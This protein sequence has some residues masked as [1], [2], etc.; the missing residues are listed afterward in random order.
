MLNDGLE[1]NS[2]E[3]DEKSQNKKAQPDAV[4]WTEEEKARRDASLFKRDTAVEAPIDAV[5]HY[6]SSQSANRAS[7]KIN[8]AF[9]EAYKLKKLEYDAYDMS[10]KQLWGDNYSPDYKYSLV[11]AIKFPVSKILSTL[12]DYSGEDYGKPLIR[13]FASS[14]RRD[15]FGINYLKNATSYLLMNEAVDKLD[16]DDDAKAIWD[17]DYVKQF[18]QDYNEDT[19]RLNQVDS[20]GDFAAY[21]MNTGASILPMILASKGAGGLLTKA[22]TGVFSKV[23]P[24]FAN[25]MQAYNRTSATVPIPTISFGYKVGAHLAYGSTAGLVLAAPV[26]AA[27]NEMALEQGASKYEAFTKSLISASPSFAFGVLP[28]FTSLNPSFKRFLGEA[29]TMGTV[30]QLMVPLEAFM[31]VS[32]LNLAKPNEGETNFDYITRMTKEG[33]WDPFVVGVLFHTM[34]LKGRTEPGVFGRV[35]KKFERNRPTAEE[36][37]QSPGLT[38]PTDPQVQPTVTPEPATLIPVPTDFNTTPAPVD[39]LLVPD[40]TQEPTGQV[41][42]TRINPYEAYANAKDGVTDIRDELDYIRTVARVSGG[43]LNPTE[44]NSG[45][46][47]RIRQISEK[48]SEFTG[49]INDENVLSIFDALQKIERNKTMFTPEEAARLE[50]RQKNLESLLESNGYTREKLLGKDYEE[51]M[52]YKVVGIKESDKYEKGREVITKVMVPSILKNGKTVQVAEIEITKGIGKGTGEKTNN[53]SFA[54]SWTQWFSRTEDPTVKK[55]IGT[56]I[57]KASLDNPIDGK[58]GYKDVQAVGFSFD[59]EGKPKVSIVEKIAGRQSTAATLIDMNEFVPADGVFHSLIDIKTLEDRISSYDELIN[60]SM[61]RQ[62]SAQLD[63]KTI[64]GK[65]YYQADY[66]NVVL[67]GALDANSADPTATKNLSEKYDQSGLRTQITT[68]LIKDRE[69]LQNLLKIKKEN[70]QNDASFSQAIFATDFLPHQQGKDFVNQIAAE[71]LSYEALISSFNSDNSFT[72]QMPRAFKNLIE[73]YGKLKNLFEQKTKQL[74]EIE[75]LFS[76]GFDSYQKGFDLPDIQ[77]KI[78]VAVLDFKNSNVVLTET[79]KALEKTGIFKIVSRIDNISKLIQMIRDGVPPDENSPYYPQKDSGN[80]VK[81]RNDWDNIISDNIIFIDQNSATLYD[82]VFGINNKLHEPDNKDSAPIVNK[83]LSVRVQEIF[84]PFTP[85]VEEGNPPQV[86]F[87][88]TSNP[89]IPQLSMR[90]SDANGLIEQ[91]RKYLETTTP[92]SSQLDYVDYAINRFNSSLYD[93]MAQIKTRL[94]ETGDENFTSISDTLRDQKFLKEDTQNR[95][96]IDKGFGPESLA[97]AFF[98]LPLDMGPVVKG[99]TLSRLQTKILENTIHTID[100]LKEL[101]KDVKT[102]K[103]GKDYVNDISIKRKSIDYGEEASTIIRQPEIEHIHLPIELNADF[104][105][106][107]T[108]KVFEELFKTPINTVEDLYKASG[109]FYINQIDKPGTFKIPLRRLVNGKFTY[110]FPDLNTLAKTKDSNLINKVI[111]LTPYIPQ[112]PDGYAYD[113]L[114]DF[115]KN[116]DL[117]NGTNNALLLEKRKNA[118]DKIN[119]YRIVID[120]FKKEISRKEQNI[121]VSLQGIKESKEFRNGSDK[122]QKTFEQTKLRENKNITRYKESIEELQ[123]KIKIQEESMAP[124]LTEATELSALTEPFLDAA[125]KEINENA[126]PLRGQKKRDTDKQELFLIKNVDDD[127]ITLEVLPGRT[128]QDQLNYL[129][130]TNLVEKLLQQQKALSNLTPIDILDKEQITYSI[131]GLTENITKKL[132]ILQSM[133][134]VPLDKIDALAKSANVEIFSSKVDDY[135]EAPINRYYANMESV[136]SF[137]IPQFLELLRDSSVVQESGERK[138]PERV[139]MNKKQPTFTNVFDLYSKDLKKIENAFKARINEALIKNPN[140]DTSSITAFSATLSEFKKAVSDI[141]KFEK[142]YAEKGHRNFSELHSEMRRVSSEVHKAISFFKKVSQ[143]VLK[144]PEGE[145]FDALDI[146]ETQETLDTGVTSNSQHAEDLIRMK[147][148]EDPEEFNAFVDL[149]VQKRRKN[150][151][152]DTDI[153]ANPI[154]ESEKLEAKQIIDTFIQNAKSDKFLATLNKEK[155]QAEEASLSKDLNK[156][157]KELLDNFLEFVLDPKYDT[158]GDFAKEYDTRFLI[159]NSGLERRVPVINE[160]TGEKEWKKISIDENLEKEPNPDVVLGRKVKPQLTFL[161]NLEEI[162]GN[163]RKAL[164]RTI[165]DVFGIASSGKDIKLPPTIVPRGT[166]PKN[167]TRAFRNYRISTDLG[168]KTVAELSTTVINTNELQ[169]GAQPKMLKSAMFV[170]SDMKKR[171]FTFDGDPSQ[172]SFKYTDVID[173]TDFVVPGIQAKTP[174][175]MAQQGLLSEVERVLGVKLN[176]SNAHSAKAIKDFFVLDKNGNHV[177]KP[178]IQIK[179]YEVDYGQIIIDG[180]K[181]PYQKNPNSNLSSKISSMDV[182]SKDINVVQKIINTLHNE[183]R[184]ETELKNLLFGNS[185]KESY[186]KNLLNAD[187]AARASSALYQNGQSLNKIMNTVF[188]DRLSNSF[189]ELPSIQ[190]SNTQSSEPA[191][192]PQPPTSE[193]PMQSTASIGVNNSVEQNTAPTVRQAKL[194]AN[195]SSEEAPQNRSLDSAELT[196][197]QNTVPFV[198]EETVPVHGQ[199]NVDAPIIPTTPILRTEEGR[200]SGSTVPLTPMP[201]E[202][203]KNDIPDATSEEPSKQSYSPKS[204]ALSWWDTQKSYYLDS[205]AVVENI[206]KSV[207]KLIGSKL[208]ESND[209]V[210]KMRLAPAQA[211]MAQERIEKEHRSIY[212]PLIDKAMTI[213]QDNPEYNADYPRSSDGSIKPLVGKAARFAHLNKKLSIY[214]IKATTDEQMASNVRSRALYDRD[215][216]TYAHLKNDLLEPAEIE[217]ILQESKE[218]IKKF[219]KDQPQLSEI[220]DEFHSNMTAGSNESLDR[221]V[222]AGKVQGTLAEK[223]KDLYPRYVPSLI[224]ADAKEDFSPMS[225]GMGAGGIQFNDSTLGIMPRFG[226]NIESKGDVYE[227]FIRISLARENA[228]NN[229]NLQKSLV[230]FLKTVHEASQKNPDLAKEYGDFVRVIEGDDSSAKSFAEK[231]KSQLAGTYQ[232]R[233]L[234]QVVFDLDGSNN[235]DVSQVDAK[236]NLIT[237]KHL[238][239]AAENIVRVGFVKTEGLSGG[240]PDA[241]PTSFYLVFNRNRGDALH[242][243]RLLNGAFEKN[244]PDSPL[245]KTYTMAQNTLSLIITG[246]NPFFGTANFFA[247]YGD[248]LTNIQNATFQKA[249]GTT[250]S[251]AGSRLAISKKSPGLSKTVY[252][253][254]KLNESLLNGKISQQQ[255]DTALGGDKELAGYA[256]ARQMGITHD[257]TD[258]FTQDTEHITKRLEKL[259]VDGDV[260]SYLRQ[261]GEAYSS[262]IKPFMSTT[263]NTVRY[264]VYKEALELGAPPEKAAL[265]AKSITANFDQKGIYARQMN[266]VYM[267]LAANLSGQQRFWSLAKSKTGQRM[268]MSLAAMG[269]LQEWMYDNVLDEEQKKSIPDYVKQ[270]YALIPLGD[271]TVAKMRI[272]AGSVPFGIGRQM[273]R[274]A[275]GNFQFSEA[276]VGLFNGLSPTGAASSGIIQTI[277]P[278]LLKPLASV[279]ENKNVFGSSISNVDPKNLVPKYLINKPT[280][281]EYANIAARFLNNI[282]KPNDSQIGWINWAGTDI[283]HVLGSY[284]GAGVI[285]STIKTAKDFKNI[286]TGNDDF[287]L[288]KNPIAKLLP[289]SRVDEKLG[290]GTSAYDA[291][292]TWESNRSMY[293]QYLF[294]GDVESA[295]KI[296]KNTR[297]PIQDAYMI[298]LNKRIDALT[299]RGNEISKTMNLTGRD[300]KL[301]A[302]LDAVREQQQVITQELVKYVGRFE[303]K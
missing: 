49:D 91:T 115:I 222:A 22:S 289:I 169:N 302:E 215:P 140:V 174:L 179:K 102:K 68:G 37:P 73:D 60:Q 167:I 189:E 214:L 218:W 298:N 288:S 154:T 138:N 223:V 82:N 160:I 229:G 259:T 172:N 196:I 75:D 83:P 20:V 129:V 184:T 270:Q 198:A 268:L 58:Y 242:M 4:F 46:M 266:S 123:Q 264:A 74:V 50:R 236:G 45:K 226:K 271:G 53:N 8:E 92:K 124:F 11:D 231:L 66:V 44:E 110:P 133:D 95:L 64:Q 77:K 258:T 244:L 175:T 125:Q 206:Y 192:T 100:Y 33:G 96:Y 65:D 2:I 171:Y 246:L 76:Q 19:T 279:A 52:N 10:V 262:L 109:E 27:K 122:R 139:L 224:A 79:S 41:A 204:H 29:A 98:K 241:K 297:I 277:M 42:P 261:M 84:K 51:G 269:F 200:T 217:K 127:N 235:L 39:P 187:Y 249:D 112:R 69:V 199:A 136:A 130:A 294:V 106:L 48:L 209:I 5:Q 245:S 230:K 9:E 14:A 111:T 128:R 86:N 276:F 260:K 145:V 93:F 67:P 263:E 207:E 159:E 72:K 143:Q 155:L 150:L 157:S 134:G 194:I 285:G 205:V 283:E 303:R 85:S 176:L 105:N 32:L 113:N 290:L 137:D 282:T 203:P 296:M 291:L 250:V 257:Y 87:L 55:F 237:R 132:N 12:Y 117:E 183:M 284:V 99:K 146:I 164:S 57:G 15:I 180:N 162:I 161:R 211:R 254:T 273:Y 251:L 35:V 47:A 275:T 232:D 94:L 188:N 38:T 114:T 193:E 178:N 191:Q 147:Q 104:K 220:F 31:D 256:A 34:T 248:L 107:E 265:I 36:T 30:N 255:F 233:L 13:S 228:I 156:Q 116:Q 168:L 120:D 25:A 252:A 301:E 148:L 151:L 56:T 190:N 78:E 97:E 163:E 299:K 286:V 177:L 293:N 6:L 103:S 213:I 247:D 142:K 61:S 54:N 225:R 81:G 18:T 7:Q 1:E 173:T 170:N 165:K 227:N 239:S 152:Q 181:I 287:K 216:E 63:P 108:L 182:I 219:K 80:E 300:N 23:A 28:T 16:M 158:F 62:L 212:Q 253:F 274:L 272:R 43:S 118:E 240:S 3:Q 71:I 17:A 208:D 202:N 186:E 221:L 210:T 89:Q 149:T 59:A 24:G 234:E 201:D 195:A 267:F 101:K 40:V 144:N 141:K 166:V 280:G 153:E 278:T 121:E 185:K 281:G 135:T 197:P 292:N 70:P 131:G 295:R 126:T 26:F 243:A 21:A 90:F 88:S 119:S 238:I